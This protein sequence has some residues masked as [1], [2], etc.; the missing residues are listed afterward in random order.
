MDDDMTKLAVR[1]VLAA[2]AVVLAG[3][4]SASAKEYDISPIF[5]LSPDKCET[6]N[7]DEEGEGIHAR[8][9]V[10]QAE[11]ERA[12][13]DWDRSMTESGLRDAIRFTCD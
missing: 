2:L 3:C 7:G 13:A 9:L 12:A 5:P 4:S 1:P 11:C 10:T 6:Y 8:C